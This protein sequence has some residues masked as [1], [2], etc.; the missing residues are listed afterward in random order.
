M[1]PVE[2]LKALQVRLG[3]DIVHET[4]HG[5]SLH[6][7]RGIPHLSLTYREIML[8]VDFIIQE[9]LMITAYVTPPRYLA[10]RGW[11]LYERIMSMIPFMGPTSFP[12][13]DEKRFFLSG[14]GDED[15]RQ[16]FTPERAAKIAA[17]FPFVEIE[18]KERVYRCLKE[19]SAEYTVDQAIKDLDLFIDF[20]E[21]TR[22][23]Q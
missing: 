10:I 6:D 1:E 8:K 18:Q 14:I 17:L 2:F 20:V 11:N 16:Y 7:E 23:K 5:A 22:V 4:K 19:Y 21:M 12:H 13:G 9:E 3:G 15:A